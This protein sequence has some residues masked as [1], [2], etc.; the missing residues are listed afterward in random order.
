[1]G[2]LAVVLALLY[3]VAR[4]W[5]G[6]TRWAAAALLCGAVVAVGTLDTPIGR[7][8]PYLT[9]PPPVPE[10]GH[11]ITPEMYHALTWIRG[12]TPSNSVIAVNNQSSSLGPSEFDYAAFAE[13]RVFLEGWGYSAPLR[14]KSFAELGDPGP[15]AGRLKLNQAAFM[16][17]DRQAL[18]TMAQQYSV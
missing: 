3:A 5:I 13:R 12:R 17:G 7:L 10:A 4:R 11:R 15:F 14:S 1:Y 2:G 6:P 8:L 16:R 18:Q 9:N